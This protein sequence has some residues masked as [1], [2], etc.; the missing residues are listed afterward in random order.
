MS[1]TTRHARI[2]ERARQERESFVAYMRGWAT[3]RD[4]PEDYD[5]ENGC[6][7]CSCCYCESVFTGYKRRVVCKV[8][9]R[10]LMEL[11]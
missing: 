4:W 7:S 6:Y 2:A 5:D 3:P 11:L 9:D 10:A 8:C 1:E